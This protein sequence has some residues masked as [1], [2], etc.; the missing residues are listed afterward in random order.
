MSL[1]VIF[2]N[3]ITNVLISLDRTVDSLP[4]DGDDPFVQ[5]YRAGH[6][7]ALVGVATAFGIETPGPVTWHV[8]ENSKRA[9]CILESHNTI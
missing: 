3:D 6:R 5:G 1:T 4:V 2:P 7:A 9:V 8:V